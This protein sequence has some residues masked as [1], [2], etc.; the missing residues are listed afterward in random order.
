M[1]DRQAVRQTD[2][3]TDRPGEGLFTMQE[4]KEKDSFK[5]H[6]KIFEETDTQTSRQ[7]DRHPDDLDQEHISW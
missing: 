6:V 7:R 2:R 1:R 3:E 4:Q 5:K